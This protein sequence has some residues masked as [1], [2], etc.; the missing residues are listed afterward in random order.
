MKPRSL[1]TLSACLCV[2]GLACT[3]EAEAE[4]CGPDA[5]VGLEVGLCAPEF[6]LPNGQGELVSLSS[7]RGK[8]ALIDISAVW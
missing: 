3:D 7:F 8:V 2:L 6:T 1:S 5:D 4:R